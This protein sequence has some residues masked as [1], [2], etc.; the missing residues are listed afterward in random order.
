MI[1]WILLVLVLIALA[2]TPFLIEE[3][4]TAPDPGNAPG[5][6][7]ELS[8]GITHY[9]W[10]GPSRGPILVAIHGLT[11]PSDIWDEI[12]TRLGEMG[13]RTL[14]Y[15]LHGR[16]YSQSFDGPQDAYHFVT[17][18][19]DLLMHLGLDD[20][21]TL[22]GYSMGGAIA[23]AYAAQNTHRM[24]R[25]MLVATAGVTPFSTARWA[26]MKGV[27]DW[28]H[29]AT[30]PGRMRW[31]IR[32]QARRQASVLSDV[33]MSQTRRRGYFPAV[34]ASRRGLLAQVQEREHKTIAREGLP[35]MAIWGEDDDVIPITAVGQLAQ[36]NREARQEVIKGADHALPFTHA[37]QVA[38][39]V[40]EVL[41]EVD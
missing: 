37:D 10:M 35:V 9:R 16:G 40:R 21:L 30:G 2:I 34:L 38:A 14:V 39:F 27:G 32:A 33:Q 4:R 25:L 5:T 3:R 19:D 28:L 41:T 29:L 13:F 18:L 36:W 6:L 24:R 23:T 20:D 31:Q 7:I 22:L 15:D 26:G 11:T 12:G 8:Q 1:W 17:Q